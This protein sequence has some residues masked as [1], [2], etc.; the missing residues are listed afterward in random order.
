MLRNKAVPNVP[1]WMTSLRS[2]AASP[3]L[4]AVLRKK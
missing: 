2:F 1:S 4:S 3:V